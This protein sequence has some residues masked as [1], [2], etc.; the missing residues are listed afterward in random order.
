MALRAT[1]DERD[2]LAQGR[3]AALRVLA[4]REQFVLDADGQKERERINSRPA[5]NLPGL[6]RLLQRPSPFG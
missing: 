4:E 6:A 2:L 1:E 3:L 5:R